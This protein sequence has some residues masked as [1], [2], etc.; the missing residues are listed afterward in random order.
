MTASIFVAPGKGFGVPKECAGSSC[1]S[2]AGTTHAPSSMDPKVHVLGSN[3]QDCEAHTRSGTK[4]FGI[5]YSQ[6]VTPVKTV[7]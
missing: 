3:I 6:R 4:D 5:Q 7:V 2:Q 1:N